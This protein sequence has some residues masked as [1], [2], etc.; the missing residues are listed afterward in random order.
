MLKYGLQSLNDKKIILPIKKSNWPDR[1]R[2]ST[3]FT[4]FLNT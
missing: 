1:D 3:R 4:R 2:L